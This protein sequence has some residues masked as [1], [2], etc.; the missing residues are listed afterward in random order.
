MSVSG[1]IAQE[2]ESLIPEIVSD[3]TDVKGET[4]EVT[5]VLNYANLTVVLTKAI[6]ELSAKVEELE[7]KINE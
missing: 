6:Q 7:S 4:D 1:F 2:V 3:T 5:K